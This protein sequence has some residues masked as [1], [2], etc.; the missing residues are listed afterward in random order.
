MRA[1]R[2]PAH[3][4]SGKVNHL[5]RWGGFGTCNLR[6][7]WEGHTP[8]RKLTASRSGR[9][10]A[11]L[12]GIP[13]LQ[14]HTRGTKGTTGSPHGATATPC[15]QARMCYAEPSPPRRTERPGTKARAEP[16]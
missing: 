6:E 1:P 15:Q 13:V 10:A 2:G 16:P 5:G 11:T 14:N 8:R 3:T 12:P 4:S 9:G 7:W